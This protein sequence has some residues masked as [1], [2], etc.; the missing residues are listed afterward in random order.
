MKVHNIRLSEINNTLSAGRG[1]LF[2]DFQTAGR[3]IKWKR[4]KLND[5]K[6][7][8]LIILQFST[9]G[10]RGSIPE[11]IAI[12]KHGITAEICDA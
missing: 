5:A 9:W 12:S 6:I 1:S 2:A 11:S 4:R 8:P 3:Q 7:E 10:A